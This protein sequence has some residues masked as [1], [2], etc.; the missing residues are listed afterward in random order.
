M[1]G[2]PVKDHSPCKVSQ[3][4]SMAADQVQGAISAF[5]LIRALCAA[6]EWLALCRRR[7]A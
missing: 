7:L 1:I 3:A 6:Q 5:D 4:A 2:K